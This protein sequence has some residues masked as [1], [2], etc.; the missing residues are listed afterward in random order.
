MSEE[1]IQ[2]GYFRDADGNI[3]P[4]RRQ[5]V[6]RRKHSVAIKFKDRRQEGRRKANEHI[7]EM[8][9]KEQIEEAMVEFEEQ[10]RHP[11]S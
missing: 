4:D 3:W 8:D 9:A 2:P 10:H 7:Q 6:E 5:F 1:D 11:E